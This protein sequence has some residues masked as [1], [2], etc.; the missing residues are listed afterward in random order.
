MEKSFVTFKE[1]NPGWTP[2]PHGQQLLEN[3]KVQQDL[4]ASMLAE[5][6]ERL[7]GVPEEPSEGARSF[8]PNL[9]ESSGL[10]GSAK[11]TDLELRISEYLRLRGQNGGIGPKWWN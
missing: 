9:A 4:T 10:R 5:S 2:G 8:G 11:F 1:N 7:Q 6:Q 3:L